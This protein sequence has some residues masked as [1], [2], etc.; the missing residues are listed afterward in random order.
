[1]QEGTR[2]P[3]VPPTPLREGDVFMYGALRGLLP[4]LQKAQRQ[5]RTWYYADNAYMRKEYGYF[6]ITKNALQHDGAGKFH[7]RK[8]RDLHLTIKPWRKT[9]SHIIVAPPDPIYGEL[10]GM[11]P[12]GWLSDAVMALRTHTDRPIE[13]RRKILSQL[14]PGTPPLAEHLKDAWALVTY[15]SNVA[16]DALLAGVPVFCSAPCASYR[17]GTPDF[18]RIEH[19]V[20][21]DDREQWAAALAA[22]QWTIKEM[23]S[24]IC[25]RELQ[26]R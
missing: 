4:T 6:R 8:W 7:P 22:N 23:R 20:M 25:W 19:P 16:V 3:V 2:A 26:A 5:G 14:A 12:I 11:D 18:S 15:T 24:G 1:M 9:G 13:I 10:W 21:P 17:M